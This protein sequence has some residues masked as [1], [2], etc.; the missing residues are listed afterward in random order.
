[1]DQAPS[2]AFGEIPGQTG[3]ERLQTAPPDPYYPPSGGVFIPRYQNLRGDPPA[4]F[5]RGFSFQAVM[6]RLP[7]PADLPAAF[8]LLGY[9]EM[10]PHHGNTV[11]IDASRTDAW[12]IPVARIRCQATENEQQLMRAQVSAITEMTQ[13]AGYR[14]TFAGS[15]L[16][17]STP[18]PF[19]KA[20][21]AT[22]LAFRV[23]F[24]H[25]MTI[26]TAIHECGGVRMGSDP[27]TSV[28]NEYNQS[29]DVP[30]LFVT[31]GSAF[32]SNGLVGPTLT[33]MAITA[34]ACDHIAREHAAGLL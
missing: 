30:N 19:P 2:V 20:G 27:A 34:R 11:T 21:P 7:T 12:G 28:L 3:S 24:R 16:G 22:R 29:W 1:M 15:A 18:K 17:L 33:I 23:G 8:A 14:L 31:D 25:A 4:P 5:A 10:L 26:G 13:V 9:G 32:A 6:G